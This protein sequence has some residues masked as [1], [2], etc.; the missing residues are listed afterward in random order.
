MNSFFLLLLLSAGCSTNMNQ[1]R[2]ACSKEQALNAENSVGLIRSWSELEHFFNAHRMCD[3]GL[4]A[5]GLTDRVGYLLSRDFEGFIKI[6][7]SAEKSN[8]SQFVINHLDESL[9]EETLHSIAHLADKCDK[10]SEEI[11]KALRIKTQNAFD[12]LSDQ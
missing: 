3:D 7:G 11:C 2:G 6:A 1:E 8:F 10:N 9:D 12:A 4:I 5:E